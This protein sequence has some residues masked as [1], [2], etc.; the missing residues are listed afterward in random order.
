MQYQLGPLNFDSKNRI[1]SNEQAAL[2]LEPKP[3]AILMTLMSA[4]GNVVSRDE[5]TTQVWQGRVVSESA[6]NKAISA[7]RQHLATLAPNTEFIETIPTLGYR[8][9]AT[10]QPLQ[11]GNNKQS[12]YKK[13]LYLGIAATMIIAIT[14]ALF[15]FSTSWQHQPSTVMQ[16]QKVM[17][18]AGIELKLSAAP[19]LQTFS[20]T[21]PI[22]A[23]LAELWLATPHGERHLFSANIRSQALSRH[24]SH[25][26]YVEQGS[27]CEVKVYNI[28]DEQHRSLFP[29]REVEKVR[30]TWGSTDQ[31]LLYRKR[32]SIHSGYGIYRYDI[33][34]N[35]HTQLTLPPTRGNLRGDH[36]FSLSY[37]NKLLA[38]ARY[39]GENQQRISL[40]SYP[41]MTLLASKEVPHNITA[42]SWS[43][44][45]ETL[46]FA[47]AT[48][49]YA[50]QRSSNQVTPVHTLTAAIESLALLDSNNTVL[51][52]QYR[53]NTTVQYYHA[54]QQKTES[55]VDNQALNRL[56]KAVI[57]NQAWYISDHG[58]NSG[59]WSI[60]TRNGN[61][62]QLPLPHPFEFQRYQISSKGT[63]VLYEYRDGIYRFDT[64]TAH[65]EQLISP[66]LKPYVANYGSTESEIIYSS[67]RSGNW[68]LWSFNTISK[69]HQQLTQYGGYSGYRQGDTLF[70]TKFT[71]P[72]IWQLAGNKESLLVAD[73]PIRNWLNWRLHNNQLY[74]ER[75]NRIWR[76]NLETDQ[77]TLHFMP[78]TGFS[79]QF[80]VL[81]NGDV[82][83]TQLKQHSGE[84]WRLKVPL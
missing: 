33:N 78:P 3:F 57:S 52:N 54:K 11:Q 34:T 31:Q 39:L 70:F 80:D 21:H 83:F 69:V 53:L 5:L 23:G 60:D 2:R 58:A 29:C 16:P 47:A 66:E 42:F 18:K 59:L 7:L 64:L 20:Y 38:V 68:Q 12:H 61:H 4:Q 43:W 71:Q 9:V 41:D 10:L 82:V 35:K 37:N 27:A 75:D 28:A 51:F 22:E 84:I 49:I 14:V 81:P 65:T 30:L 25:I 6:I 50:L 74:Y 72:G 17:G 15:V 79:H 55:L 63:E 32:E 44:D 26:A 36:L 77:E 48:S 76:Y 46:Y 73:V 1:L 19:N 67:E 62:H 40:F 24:A 56:P 13:A 45:T 8:L